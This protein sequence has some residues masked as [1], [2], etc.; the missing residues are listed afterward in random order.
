MQDPRLLST[1]RN[2]GQPRLTACPV[3]NLQPDS[4]WP[5]ESAE[6]RRAALW[7]SEMPAD[8]HSD[9]LPLPPP[10][11][12]CAG[13][14]LSYFKRKMKSC[15]IWGRETCTQHLFICGSQGHCF[16]VY[17]KL[18]G[19]NKGRPPRASSCRVAGRPSQSLQ[20]KLSFKGNPQKVKG[21]ALREFPFLSLDSY[22]TLKRPPVHYNGQW[23]IRTVGPF[24]GFME[25]LWTWSFC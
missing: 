7:A 8:P 23:G 17:H 24:E 15:C 25:I 11:C 1:G 13:G 16:M 18:K 12:V 4:H 21:A 9:T 6:Q 14:W 19:K 5:C 3:P 20:K 10:G 2:T 22:Q